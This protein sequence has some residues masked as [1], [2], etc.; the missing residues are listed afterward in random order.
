MYHEVWRIERAYFYDPHYHGVNTVE[1]ERRFEPYVDS[2]ASRADLNYIFQEMLTGFS[3][4]HLRGHGGAIPEAQHVPGGLLGADYTI[5]EQPLLHREDLHGRD[6]VAEREGAAGAAGAERA[7]GRL[8]SRDQRA[9]PDGGDEHPGAARGHGGAR[10]HAADRRGER[11][12]R[13]RDHGCA[14]PERAAAS[15]CGLDRGEP[16]QGGSALGRQAGVCLPAGH[17][18]GRIHELQSLLH[19]ADE[20]G[21]RDRRRALQRRRAGGRL[22][23]RGAGPA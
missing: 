20:Q 13:A 16:A 17:G 3:V 18:R 21:G 9:E 19:G 5:N 14:D 15:Q 1:E 4:G 22:H 2:I 23:H 8:H 7:C 6:V 10:D 11:R 12:G